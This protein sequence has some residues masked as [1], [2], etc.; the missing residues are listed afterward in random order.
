MLGLLR[1][2]A[3][4][5]L[6]AAALNVIVFLI[7]TQ[8]SGALIVTMPAETEV[9][10]IQPFIFSLMLGII[11][12]VIAGFIALRTGQ[13]RRTWIIIAIGAL[14]LYGVPPFLSAGVTTALWF[15]VMH[16]V[17]GLCLIPAVAA[18]LPESA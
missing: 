15:N 16:A 11:G 1:R 12:S 2:A 9:T 14:I 18:Q 7:A 6:L 5:S 17:A 3:I 13:P 4:Y 10:L 8:I